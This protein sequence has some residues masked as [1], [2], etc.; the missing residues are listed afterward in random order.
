MDAG[1]C[2][3]CGLISTWEEEVTKEIKEVKERG[4]KEI[5]EK[6]KEEEIKEIKDEVRKAVSEFLCQPTT[7][8]RQPAVVE[9]NIS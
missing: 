7:A 4:I 3:P 2:I 5:K 8:L 1:T 9:L 6:V